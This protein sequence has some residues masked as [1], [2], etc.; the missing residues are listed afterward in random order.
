MEFGCERGEWVVEG[1]LQIFC[2]F[3]WYLI[4]SNNKEI[5]NIQK[6]EKAGIT[7]LILDKADFRTRKIIRD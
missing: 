7:I 3:S 2:I 1:W 4:I 6:K 5:S